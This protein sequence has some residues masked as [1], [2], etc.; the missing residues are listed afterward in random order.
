MGIV[1]AGQ[2]MAGAASAE[3]LFNKVCSF[4]AVLMVQEERI[5]CQSAV[6]IGSATGKIGVDFILR[7]KH[8][9]LV[10]RKTVPCIEG[11]SFFC[12]LLKHSQHPIRRIVFEA[13]DIRIFFIR[14]REAIQSIYEVKHILLT[15]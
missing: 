10:P 4:L 1:R 11:Y 7:D 3:L 5:C 9:M 6:G 12:K 13:H 2:G 15:R 8:F 14:R